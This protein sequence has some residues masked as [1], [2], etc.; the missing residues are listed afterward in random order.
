M[1][2]GHDNHANPSGDPLRR[3]KATGGAVAIDA[4]PN[5]RPHFTGGEVFKAALMRRYEKRVEEIKGQRA[6]EV[7]AA[8]DRDWREMVRLARR[9]TRL[10]LRAEALWDA[11]NPGWGRTS[12]SSM[13]PPIMEGRAV[14]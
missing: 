11:A 5:R 6:A 8:E 7:A 14:A 1:R 2:N 4:A 13:L 12:V 10:Y 3:A 9:H